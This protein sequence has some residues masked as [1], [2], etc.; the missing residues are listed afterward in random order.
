MFYM[1]ELE[2]SIQIYYSPVTD[3]LISWQKITN[4]EVAMF[5]CE[6]LWFSLHHA[7][8]E[9]AMCSGKDARTL[10]QV[11]QNVM[12]YGYLLWNKAQPMSCNT[13]SVLHIPVPTRHYKCDSNAPELDD[14][15]WRKAR[16]YIVPH[17]FIK[18]LLNIIQ[19]E[20][21]VIRFHL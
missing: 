7:V 3:G 4:L 14:C 5:L 12:H 6:S 20:S 10:P 18:C 19:R 13:T 1:I 2:V 8:R 15:R 11:L 9:V 17:V 21:V 16:K